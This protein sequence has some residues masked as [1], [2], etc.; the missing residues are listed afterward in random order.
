MDKK[1]HSILRIVLTILLG[2]IL[3][4][5]LVYFTGVIYFQ[6]HFPFHTMFLD[7]DI[8]E[9]E[10]S[11]IDECMQMESESRSLT[12]QELDGAEE[13]IDLVSEIDYQRSVEE[14]PGGWI[15]KDSSWR[16]PLSLKEET[17]LTQE[18]TVSYSK[19]KL[20]TVIYSLDAMDPA[21]VTPPQDA[22]LEWQDD[23]LVL[24]PEVDGNRLYPHQVIRVLRNAVENDIMTVDL[25]EEGCYQKATLRS[26][27]NMLQLTLGRYQ[28]INFKTIDID[29][30]GE[31]ITLSPDDVLQ[32]YT[33]YHIT[34]L[35]LSEEAVAAYVQDLKDRYD[36]YERQRPF[37]NRYGNE[38]NVGSWADTYGFRMD[39]D[40][41]I[42]LLTETLESHERHA[43][44]APVWVNSGWTRTENGG[45][46]GSTYIEV[47]ISEQYLWAY[48]D[49]EM[50]LSS[51][52]VT[53]NAG[54]HDT[55]RG[56]FRILYKQQDTTLE[57]DDYSSPVS[58]WMPLTSSGVGLHDATWRSSFGGS[59]YTYS[60][61]HGCV[62][63]PYWAASDIYW[64][65]S[66]G[67]PVVIW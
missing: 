21:N 13:V 30:T 35:R 12:I 17:D 42:A 38:I 43:Q 7:Y 45:D 52:V 65:F 41:T 54:D 47:S 29:M 23:V 61:S 4:A 1:N 57:G 56:V 5:A 28:S 10:V 51:S 34:E 53:G 55:P 25:A 59:I 64:T 32:F 63:L 39:L 3:M 9:R 66:A 2:A 18:V 16:W 11:A 49:G 58:F 46:I 19:E 44:I 67:T 27:D 50:V 26:D 22:Y 36:T 6:T 15:P 24:V 60:G 48:V 37:V 62:N 20:T 8:S 40:A 14:P 31:T 33:P